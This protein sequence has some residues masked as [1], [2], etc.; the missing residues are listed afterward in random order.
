MRL[1][2][3]SLLAERFISPRYQ[4]NSKALHRLSN[5]QG[6]PFLNLFPLFDGHPDPRKLYLHPRDGHMSAAGHALMGE[7]LS[8]L[9]LKGKW[10]EK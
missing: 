6:I 10:F 3:S 1:W 4:G 5:A 9:I 2:R 7:A 8:E